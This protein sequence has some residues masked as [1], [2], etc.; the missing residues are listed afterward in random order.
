MQKY[1]AEEI[2]NIG[3]GRDISIKELALLIKEITGFKGKIVFD[4]SKPDGIARKLLDSRRI[5]SLGWKA[6]VS[7]EEGIRRTYEEFKKSL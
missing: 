4:I 7:L 2:I 3:F 5:R 1:S 6:S